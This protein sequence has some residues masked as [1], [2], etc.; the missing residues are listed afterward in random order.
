MAHHRALHDSHVHQGEKADAVGKVIELV[1]N[2]AR[3][4]AERTGSVEADRPD[5]ILDEKMKNPARARSSVRGAT[6]I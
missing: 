1:A 6:Q 2:A 4:D 3:H 5:R